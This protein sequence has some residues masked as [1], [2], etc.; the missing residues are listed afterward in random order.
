MLL[1]RA[2]T[3]L[4][5]LSVVIVVLGSSSG[6]AAE[7]LRS[8]GPNAEEPSFRGR[9]FVLDDP[10]EL[11]QVGRGEPRLVAVVDYHYPERPGD[12]LFLDTCYNG[13]HCQPWWSVYGDRE[14]LKGDKS[15]R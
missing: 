1:Q 3:L 13:H 15:E 7:A 10:V 2:F 11:L 5:A 6:R 4:A 8:V 9:H 14:K 12:R